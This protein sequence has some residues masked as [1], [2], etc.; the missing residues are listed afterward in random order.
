[1]LTQKQRRT[2][3]GDADGDARKICAHKA[4]YRCE[5]CGATQ[6]LEHHHVTLKSQSH[7]SVRLD[8]LNGVCL[9]RACH[10]WAHS[11]RPAFLLWLSQHDPARHEFAVSPRPVVTNDTDPT[12]RRDELKAEWEAMQ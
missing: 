9:C 1:M 3:I 12:A 8:S 5:R 10:A 7:W 4:G 2:I 6:Y 11:Y